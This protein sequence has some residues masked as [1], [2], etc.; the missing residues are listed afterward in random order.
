MYIQ[1]LA[2]PTRTR[3]ASLSVHT[4]SWSKGYRSGSMI[5]LPDAQAG[6]ETA[7]TLTHLQLVVV[8]RAFRCLG[9]HPI[10]RRKM[11]LKGVSV[12]LNG[13]LV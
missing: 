10:V 6:G 2:L 1:Y 7:H 13:W 9:K 12:D 8:A 3:L 11:E 4:H 5:R